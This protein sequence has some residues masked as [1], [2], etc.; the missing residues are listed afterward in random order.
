M[1]PIMHM[2]TSTPNE[3]SLGRGIVDP[4]FL[5]LLFFLL[6]SACGSA[7]DQQEASDPEVGRS[8]IYDVPLHQSAVADSTNNTSDHEV[9]R[10]SLSV[11]ESAGFYSPARIGNMPPF[12]GLTLCQ[13][14]SDTRPDGF[15]RIWQLPNAND[16]LVL[17]GVEDRPGSRL[18]IMVER[19]NIGRTC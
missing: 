8:R 15:K 11:S 18:M 19:G 16:F 2:L 14:S 13:N 7:D 1:S 10:L 4:I 12:R 6:A 3:S 9:Y 17:R 5:L